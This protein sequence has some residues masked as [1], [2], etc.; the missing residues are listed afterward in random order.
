MAWRQKQRTAVEDAQ[1]CLLHLTCA[2]LQ[3][4]AVLQDEEVKAKFKLVDIMPSKWST[5]ARP[6]FT[7]AQV[8]RTSIGGR[9]TEV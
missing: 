6:V 5:R 9:G 2:G 7:N 3:V 4:A 8:Y 1:D